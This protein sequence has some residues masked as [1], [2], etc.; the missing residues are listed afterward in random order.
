M[1]KLIFK[2]IYAL[3]Y[4]I[5]MFCFP[6]N[7]KVIL[8]ESSV[9][10]N[11][12]GNPKYIYEE[13]VRQ[14]LDQHYRC[15]WV[16][17]DPSINIPGKCTLIKRNG[18]QQLFYAAIAFIW[19]FD[20][21]QS[22]IF[23]KRSGSIFI[24]T[25]HGTPLKK[26]AMDMTVLNMGGHTDLEQYKRD[27]LG[28]VNS[29][30]Y[31]ISQN[32][33]STEVFRHAF[34]F[35]KE[36]WE[37]GYPRN[38]SLFMNH[39]SKQILEI[40]KKLNIA[41]EKK[42]VLYAPTWRDDEY[43]TSG[44]WILNLPGNLHKLIKQLNNEYT[45]LIKGHYLVE[46][47]MAS[48]ESVRF[49]S[50]EQDIQELLLISDVLITDY[51]SVMFDFSLLGKPMIFYLYDFERYK[52]ELRGFYFNIVDEAPG[53]VVFYEEELINILRNMNT[54][55]HSYHEKYLQF[56][57]KFNHADDGHASQRVVEKIKSI[58]MR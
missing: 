50:Y 9:G 32:K 26:L 54:Y 5:L 39:N 33:Y 42:V 47:D 29:W 40:K 10:R 18:L 11:Y 44:R 4:R 24:Q 48:S 53:P 55:Q 31:L 20:S 1:S 43:K 30:D 57:R 41:T 25:W 23:K 35:K 38:D 7:K 36:I 16:F 13:M 3:I 56:V 49:F 45:F 51:S 34:D 15:V 37:I 52:N 58:S 8:F 22:N 12:T 19:I 6:I 28:C 27:F 46:M 14:G 17:E 2:R 21:R